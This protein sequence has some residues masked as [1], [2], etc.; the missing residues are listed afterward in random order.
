MKMENS[1]REFIK[2]LGWSEKRTVVASKLFGY[3][4]AKLLVPANTVQ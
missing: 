4:C 2:G 3:D 1:R